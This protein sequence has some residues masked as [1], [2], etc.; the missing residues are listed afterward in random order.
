M[1][2]GEDIEKC[3]CSLLTVHLCLSTIVSDA[4]K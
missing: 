3:V 4:V 2:S 1:D